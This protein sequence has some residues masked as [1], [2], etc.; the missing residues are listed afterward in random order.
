MWQPPPQG[1][2][3]INFDAGLS[4]QYSSTNVYLIRDHREMRKGVWIERSFERAFSA[5]AMA[6]QL[7]LKIAFF[8]NQSNTS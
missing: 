5:E 1:W 4:L 8:E 7:A 6:A 3:K 2:F